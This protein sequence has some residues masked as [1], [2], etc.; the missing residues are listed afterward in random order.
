MKTAGN[1]KLSHDSVNPIKIVIY[2][3]RQY[4]I[5]VIYNVYQLQFENRYKINHPKS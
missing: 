2:K 4:D 3:E 5:Y 1:R